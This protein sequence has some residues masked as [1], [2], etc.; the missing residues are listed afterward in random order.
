MRVVDLVAEI[1]RLTKMSDPDAFKAG[2]EKCGLKDGPALQDAFD[3]WVR[4]WK[5]STAP[6]PAE[7]AEH[8]RLPSIYTP[9]VSGLTNRD[10]MLA[11]MEL[12]NRPDSY[13]NTCNE[14]RDWKRGAGRGP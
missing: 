3:G 12:S 1:G 10:R 4:G 8:Y 2:L 11:D 5:R 9:H 14:G 6:Q 7:F 13:K